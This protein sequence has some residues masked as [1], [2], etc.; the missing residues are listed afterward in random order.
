MVIH[1][2]EFTQTVRLQNI[3]HSSYL[4]NMSSLTPPRISKNHNHS[5]T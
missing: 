3:E 4:E 1:S 2:N 5:V